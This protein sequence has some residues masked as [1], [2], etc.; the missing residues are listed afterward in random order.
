[1]LQINTDLRDTH[2]IGSSTSEKIISAQGCH[3][4]SFHRIHLAG[5]S[6]AKPPFRFVRTHPTMSQILVCLSGRGNVW[7]DGHWEACSSGMAYLT[8]PGVLHAYHA[9][10]EEQWELCWL[11]YDEQQQ[12]STLVTSKTPLLIHVETQPVA[13][14]I[15]ELYREYMGPADQALMQQW[16]QLLDSYVR[17]IIGQRKQDKRLLQLWATV[18]NDLAYTWT[19]E[20]LATH[21][22]ISSEH[23]RRLC[24]QQLGH[25]PMK[26]L[27]S[28]RMRR[29]MVLLTNDAYSIETVALNVGYQNPFAF[30]TAFKR[31]IGVSPSQYRQHTRR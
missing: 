14:L 9:V 7:L 3:A 26:Q 1:M 19:S 15:E 28:L 2:I 17:R 31:H 27:T 11:L 23:L 8:P 21:L 16:T 20:Q 18:S 4:F 30:S 13:A 22:G 24:V 25:S 12:S 10:D 5:L 29:A 6:A